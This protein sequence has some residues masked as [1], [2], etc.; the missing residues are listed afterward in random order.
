MNLQV[1]ESREFN[2]KS[3]DSLI[4][5]SLG[6]SWEEN[7]ISFQ[8]ISVDLP[9]GCVQKPIEISWEEWTPDMYA[10]WSPTVKFNHYIGP[11]WMST[12]TASCTAVGMP[13]QTILD[14]ADNNCV[15]VAASDAISPLRISMGVREEDGLLICK[16][17]LF[18]RPLPLFSHYEVTL[19]IDRRRIPYYQAVE[20]VRKWW[21]SMGYE[22]ANVPDSAKRP[23]YSSWYSF[24]QDLDSERLLQQCRLAVE[25]GMQCI[26]IDAGWEHDQVCSGF[27]HCGDW[28]PS[29]KKY[30]ICGVFQMPYM[31]LV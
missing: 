20:E 1:I 18:D 4:Q 27:S 24:H 22:N 23:M 2:L 19:R 14:K 29:E 31:L 12:E 9:E 11:E 13:V 25:Y 15:T 16:L 26:I 10:V 3:D 30:R 6:T 21:S 8:T 5:L 7:G 28:E 17:I